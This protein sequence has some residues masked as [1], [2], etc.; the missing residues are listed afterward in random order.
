MNYLL[1]NWMPFLTMLVQGGLLKYAY[2]IY[3][4]IMNHA[5][6]QKEKDQAMKTAIRSLLRAEIIS[7]CHK[8]QLTGYIALYNL[9]NLND[10]YN[11]YHL[12]GGNGSISKIYSKAIQLP[13]EPPDMLGGQNNAGKD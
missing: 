1:E 13:N 2:K 3:K 12:L 8:S 7:L 6:E 10:M 4:D 11:A 5:E 9:E